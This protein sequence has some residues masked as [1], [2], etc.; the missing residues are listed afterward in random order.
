VADASQARVRIIGVDI[1]NIGQPRNDGTPGSALYTVPIT[2]NTAPSR[3]WSAAFPDVW[4]HPPSWTSK[5]RPGIAH[6]AGNRI[7][8]DGTTL[9]EVRDYHAAT[10]KLVVEKL[11]NAEEQYLANQRAQADRD[12]AERTEH[13]ANARSVAE[14]IRF[15]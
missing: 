11:N 10:L 15:D 14:N 7:I 8:L 6:V 4:D 1:E 13:N 3:E 9:E 12:A 5:H 2:L